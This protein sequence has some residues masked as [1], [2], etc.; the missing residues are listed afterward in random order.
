MAN[1]STTGPSGIGSEVLRRVA[2]TDQ[3]ATTS[4]LL[5][6]REDSIYTV[7]SIIILDDDSGNN[8]KINIFVRIDGSTDHYLVRDQPINYR[9]TFIFNEKFVMTETDILKVSSDCNTFDVYVS[10]ID[11]EF[12]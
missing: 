4:T 12:A 7:T 1:P 6:V 9:E 3:N 10:Y 2:A 11:Q 8:D 5:T